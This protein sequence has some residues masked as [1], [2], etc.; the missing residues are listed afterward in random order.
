MALTTSDYATATA[1]KLPPRQAPAF[2]E[3]TERAEEE[4]R[5]LRAR[6]ESLAD[7]LCGMTPETGDAS[8]GLREVPAGVFDTIVSHGRSISQNVSR[9]REALDRIERSLP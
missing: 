2:T 3:A 1:N 4:V 5:V 6:I 8:E 7:R 9:S